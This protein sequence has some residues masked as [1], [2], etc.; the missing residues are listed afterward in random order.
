[1]W[2]NRWEYL[3]KTHKALGSVLGSYIRFA[4]HAYNP[5]TEKWTAWILR[6]PL[7]IRWY[8]Q[9]GPDTVKNSTCPLFATLPND[10]QEEGQRLPGDLIRVNSL[11]HASYG[12]LRAAEE[13]RYVRAKDFFFRQKEKE[14]PQW[15]NM[16]SLGPRENIHCATDLTPL[17]SSAVNTKYEYILIEPF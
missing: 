12:G 6:L 5:S 14:A 10:S 17:T 4:I 7:D 15:K 2:P 3:P 9:P 8:F 11:K 1:M 16:S 13:L